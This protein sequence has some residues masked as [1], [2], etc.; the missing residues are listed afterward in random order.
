MNNA[1]E[2][3]RVHLNDFAEN[4]ILPLQVVYNTVKSVASAVGIQAQDMARQL[5]VDIVTG[6][7]LLGSGR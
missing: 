2:A 3:V 4:D 7:K 5:H 6:Q 1:E